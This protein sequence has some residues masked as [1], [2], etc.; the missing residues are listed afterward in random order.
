MQKDGNMLFSIVGA[1]AVL[2]LAVFL[3]MHLAFM[4][5]LPIITY[6]GIFWFTTPTSL[7]EELRLEYGGALGRKLS[8]IYFRAVEGHKI[9]ENHLSQLKQNMDNFTL[10][11]Y[12]ESLSKK[13]A[14]I[15]EFL[16][17]KENSG[18]LSESENFFKY[19]YEKIDRIFTNYR[20]VTNS[21]ASVRLQ[22]I[23]LS[24]TL[25][26]LEYLN[27]IFSQQL[28]KYYNNNINELKSDSNFLADKFAEKDFEEQK[29]KEQTQEVNDLENLQ[30]EKD[31]L[32]QKF[33][34]EMLNQNPSARNTEGNETVNN[35]PFEYKEFKAQAFGP[36]D[37]N[38]KQVA[39]F[40]NS[41][42]SFT[43]EQNLDHDHDKLNQ[44]NLNR[45][46]LEQGNFVPN[47]L[48]QNNLEHLQN[49]QSQ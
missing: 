1:L 21:G 37:F 12:T 49:Q 19:Y 9:L 27:R 29:F 42:G 47:D 16:S 34:E 20:N 28:D 14:S 45:G 46:N 48:T 24:E 17:K 26:S 40:T 23:A 38:E 2:L 44:S 25:E 4:I 30:A 7:S 13:S 11:T 15:I 32:E 33:S 10:V 18:L 36:N 8:G 5:V 6:F 39:N 31:S 35:T 22:D 43:Q 41:E 3:K